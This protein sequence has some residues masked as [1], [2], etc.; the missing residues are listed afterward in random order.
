[1][2]RIQSFFKKIVKRVNFC[3]FADVNR[4]I[5]F[6]ILCVSKAD[7]ASFE[8]ENANKM[9]IRNIICTKSTAFD[10]ETLLTFGFVHCRSK[11]FPC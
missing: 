7:F 8:K 1:M 3:Y 9:R 11:L 4:G 6:Q 10:P 5:H 2:D